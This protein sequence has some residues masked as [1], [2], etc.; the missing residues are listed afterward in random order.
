MRTTLTYTLEAKTLNIV[1][2]RIPAPTRYFPI[3]RDG[4]CNIHGHGADSGGHGADPGGRGTMSPQLQ[5]FLSQT[6]MLRKI[7]YSYIFS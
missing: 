2:E 1:K 3:L 5:C 6:I 4:F 7:K